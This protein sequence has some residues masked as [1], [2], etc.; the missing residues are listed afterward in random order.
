MA[1]N[2]TNAAEPVEVNTTITKAETA[3]AAAPVVEKTTRAKT[4]KAADVAFCV[5]LG[6]T[7]HG[8][9]QSGTIYN[10]NRK[11][12]E[13]ALAEA[14]EK[15]PLIAKLIVT[16]KTLAED[17]IKVK[18]SGNALNVFYRKLASGKSI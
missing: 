13:K 15:Y 2:K 6:P 11:A 18:T 4:E 3:A 5:Y 14:I 9:I 12:T 16:D 7:I 17:R 8:V 10:G 1:V